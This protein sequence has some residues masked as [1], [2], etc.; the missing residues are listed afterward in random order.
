MQIPDY[1]SGVFAKEAG[2]VKV[3]VALDTS[4]DLSIQ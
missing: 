2:V 3:R 4:R 1:L